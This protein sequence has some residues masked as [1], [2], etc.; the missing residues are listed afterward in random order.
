MEQAFLK[1]IYKFF[2]NL[3]EV[4]GFK[5]KTELNEG[6]S[7]LIEYSS[8][9]FIIKIQKYFREFYVTLYKLNKPDYEINLFNLLEYLRKGDRQVPKSEYFHDEK[10]I[11]ECYRKQFA[12]ISSV[13]YDNY[14]L[15]ND[16]FRES[17]YELN[18]ME[19]EK[20]WKDK[21][22]EFYKKS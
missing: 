19:F 15:I 17:E 7:Y 21:H 2:K 5:T 1:Y 13:V 11:E 9:N 14:K 10:D 12:H 18:T 16:F 20:F 6:Q 4:Y 8:D 3:I 22:P